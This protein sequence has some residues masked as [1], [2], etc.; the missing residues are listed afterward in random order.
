MFSLKK[1]DDLRAREPQQKKKEGTHTR[2]NQPKTEK[3]LNQFEF[4]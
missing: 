2:P 3:V 1:V 4:V